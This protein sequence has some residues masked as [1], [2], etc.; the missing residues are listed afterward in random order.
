MA[1]LTHALSSAEAYVAF[2]SRQPLPVLR[3]TVDKFALLG[4]D[5]ENVTRTSIAAAVLADPL[6]A[7]RLLSYIE[8]HRKSAQN[9]DIVTI[10]S[11]LVMM[12]I[13]PFFRA[14]GNL[15]TVED[16][17]GEQPQIL[18]GL[19]KVVSR[20]CKAARYARAWAVIRHDLDVNEITVAA[21]LNESAEI[22][23]WIHAPDLTRRVYDMQRAD[24]TLR[25]ATAQR[26]VFGVTSQE[27]QLGLIRAWGLPELL[28][29]LLDQSQSEN[30]RVRTIS[31]ASDFARHVAR[32]WDNP[33]LSDDMTCLMAL[34]RIPPEAMLRRIGAPEEVWPHLLPAAYGGA[35]HAKP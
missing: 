34:L 29:Q 24:R 8:T 9:H 16:A 30:P 25:S 28:V 33:A 11:A 15:P 23:A 13:I 1:L 18:L 31:L 35:F 20:S 7:M 2:F 6:M 27:I 17:L 12:G 21:L 5:L 10:S 32:G 3:R 26:E 4:K 14:F 19:L 22:M